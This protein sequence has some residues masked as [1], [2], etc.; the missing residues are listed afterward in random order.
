[1]NSGFFSLHSVCQVKKLKSEVA[2]QQRVLPLPALSGGLPQARPLPLTP[3]ACSSPRALS[4]ALFAQDSGLGPQMPTP[5]QP[6]IQSPRPEAME[7]V[8]GGDSVSR[9]VETLSRSVCSTRMY[10]HVLRFSKILSF[11]IK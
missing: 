10:Q 3:E 8:P 5:Q 9:S 7:L 2:G 4:P 1:M 6:N 11:Y